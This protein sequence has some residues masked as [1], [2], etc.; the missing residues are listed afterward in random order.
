[1]LPL[2]AY[3]VRGL[4]IALNGHCV[5]S[6]LEHHDYATKTAEK[7]C[8]RSFVTLCRLCHLQQLCGLLSAAPPLRHLTRRFLTGKP[9][10]LNGI[11][12]I[13]SVLLS[14]RDGERFSAIWIQSQ[15]FFSN[16]VATERC[17]ART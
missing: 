9:L 8:R 7:L 16:P 3:L 5:G 10:F 6:L 12:F 4:L 2:P 17:S 13:A 11:L 14:L 15:R 1:M